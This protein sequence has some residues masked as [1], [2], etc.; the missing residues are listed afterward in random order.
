MLGVACGGRTDESSSPGVS[1]L[2]YSPKPFTKDMD[3]MTVRFTT[4]GPAGDSLSGNAYS[5]WVSTGKDHRDNDCY[6]EFSSETKVPG[7]P[8]KTYVQDIQMTVEGTTDYDEDRSY[9]ACVGRAEI[10]VALDR[11]CCRPKVMRTLSFRVL[12]ARSK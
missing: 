6:D 4:T 3:E 9:Q 11:D 10:V 12:P 8:G 7:E 1:F 5:V 2:D